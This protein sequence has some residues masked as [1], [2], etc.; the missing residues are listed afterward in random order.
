MCS[1]IGYL[2]HNYF[3]PSKGYAIIFYDEAI[4]NPSSPMGGTGKG[5]I[6]NA[7]KQF[8]RS[9]KIDGKLMIDGNRF[10]FELVN[11]DT[12]IV[13]ID[14]PRKD[15]AFESLFSCLTDGWTVERKFL[16]QFYIQPEA[17]PKVLICSNVVLNRNGTSNKRRQF[18]VELNDYYSKQLVNGNET[19]IEK[20]HGILFKEEWL[21]AEWDSFYSF[22]IDNVLMYLKDGLIPYQTKNVEINFLVQ[23]TNED[24]VEYMTEKNFKLDVWY[25]TKKAFDDFIK[26]YYGEDSNFKQRGFTNWLKRYAESIKVDYDNSS[27][28]GVTKFI[29]ISP[30]KQ[31]TT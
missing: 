17:S 23:N 25:D 10:K 21:Q 4:T 29:F 19:P 2:S 26:L 18:S 9:T 3:D 1:A 5:L 6:A 24:F 20:E 15:F 22:M 12:Q 7:L 30:P 13:W 8:R 16:P 27:S 14:D 11:P 28:G 31:E